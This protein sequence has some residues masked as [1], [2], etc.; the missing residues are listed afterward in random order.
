MGAIW[1]GLGFQNGLRGVGK[2]C[3]QNNR[4][5]T[6]GSIITA[7]RVIYDLLEHTYLH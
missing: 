6:D 2:E 4:W 5:T 7:V 1:H 3:R